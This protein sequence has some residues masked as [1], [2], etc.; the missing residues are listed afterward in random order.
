MPF[1][2]LFLVVCSSFFVLLFK[3]VLVRSLNNDVCVGFSPQQSPFK[4][5][6]EPTKR[7]PSNMWRNH[8]RLCAQRFIFSNGLM[9]KLANFSLKG[10]IVL[11]W[12]KSS[13]GF[14][15]KILRKNPNELFG[16]PNT[17]IGF[18]GHAIH[19]A[20]TQLCPCSTIGAIDN[21]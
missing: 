11:G 9:Q 10:Q 17:Y 15:C 6:E 7:L 2:C 12:P 19:V 3:P 1:M 16:Q 8:F 13:F 20:T 5:G 21:Q 14:S 4:Y 18:L